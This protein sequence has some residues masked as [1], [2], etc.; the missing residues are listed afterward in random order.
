MEK[1][2]GR[3]KSLSTFTTSAEKL[4]KVV[5]PPRKPVMMTSRQAGSS[6]A[7]AGKKAMARPMR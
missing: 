3:L 5:R 4:E 6:C 1:E 7:M 2:K